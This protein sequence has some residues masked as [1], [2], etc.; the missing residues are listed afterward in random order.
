MSFVSM[1]L[2]LAV[3]GVVGFFLGG[4]GGASYAVSTHDV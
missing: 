1:V 4:G 3:V 2:V